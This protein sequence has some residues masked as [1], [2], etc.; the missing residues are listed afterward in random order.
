MDETAS[1]A[2]ADA[3]VALEALADVVDRLLDPVD[4]CVWNR[5]QT[6]RT[7][8]RYVVEEAYELVDAIDDDDPAG[9]REELGDV[10]Y[11]VVLQAGVAERLGR[12]S[13]AEVADAA[14]E[15]MTR[16]H[17]HVFGAER[18]ETLADVVRVWQAAKRAEKAHRRDPFDGVP[19][20][21][22]PLERALMAVE[23]TSDAL[24]VI[25]SVGPSPAADEAAANNSRAPEMD[26][27]WGLSMLRF[28]A[29]ARSAGIDVSASLRAA[30]AAFEEAARS[31]RA[32]SPGV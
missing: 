31:A 27:S 24:A 11:Q 32:E 2:N 1:R 18:A 13:F 16:R 19:R 30:T 20:A 22:P 9:M 8:A 17:P 12:F 10:L 4:G 3:G 23:R 21:M 29:E 5:A 7:L 6:H 26:A 15:K 25:D 14:R 28:V